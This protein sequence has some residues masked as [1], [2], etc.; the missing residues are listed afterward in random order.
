MF[1]LN[2]Q[3]D[4][5]LNEADFAPPLTIGLTWAVFF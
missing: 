4:I 2:C 3:Y 1:E 5:E